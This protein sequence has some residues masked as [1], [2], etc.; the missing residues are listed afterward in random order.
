[1]YRAAIKEQKGRHQPS[2]G[3]AGHSRAIPA[4]AGEKYE[5]WSGVSLND[6]RIHYHSDAPVQMKKDDHVQGDESGLGGVIQRAEIPPADPLALLRPGPGRPG[7]G[8]GAPGGGG[9]HVALR[10]R[11]LNDNAIVVRGGL[12]SA[13]TL[14]TN[15]ANDRNAYISANSANDV[16]LDI[17]A[18]SPGPFPNGSLTVSDVGRIRNINM[19][20]IPEPTRNNRYHAAIVPPRLRTPLTPA[21]A[22]TLNSVF[23]VVEN[24]W[25][26]RRQQA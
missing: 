15:Q 2:F 4:G 26:P 25:R 21:E 8:A 5:A 10:D 7:E 3:Q 19:N 20:V 12:S 14:M 11:R 17:L 18:T 13:G 16:S 9:D 22:G 24:R 23:T 1:M 6:M